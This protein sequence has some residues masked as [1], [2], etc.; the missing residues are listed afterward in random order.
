MSENDRLITYGPSSDL[1]ITDESGKSF[2]VGI[3]E[4]YDGSFKLTFGDDVEYVT[5]EEFHEILR[6]GF[7][8]ADAELKAQLA[9]VMR[10]GSN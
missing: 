2:E 1:G 7:K 10:R 9:K 6:E 8:A 4:L 5:K 3:D